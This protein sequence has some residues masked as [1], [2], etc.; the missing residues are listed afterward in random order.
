MCWPNGFAVTASS[1]TLTVDVPVQIPIDAGGCRN[2]LTL[3]AP[4]HC[5]SIVAVHWSGPAPGL[6]TVHIMGRLAVYALESYHTL[7][8]AHAQENEAITHAGEPLD[9]RCRGLSHFN[10][11][12]LAESFWTPSTSSRVLP[13][14]KTPVAVLSASCWA[15]LA[16]WAVRCGYDC[17]GG[18]GADAVVAPHAVSLLPITTQSTGDAVDP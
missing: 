10:A 16:T 11:P 4:R 13:G 8:S 3:S 5:L 14:E 7:E 2:T 17:F 18:T 12:S 1:V 9:H 15:S 6:Q